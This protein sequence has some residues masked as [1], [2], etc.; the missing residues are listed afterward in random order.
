MTKLN[1]HP[2]LAIFHVGGYNLSFL[3]TKNCTNADTRISSY[4]SVDKLFI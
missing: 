3:E 2:L 4:S 1:N